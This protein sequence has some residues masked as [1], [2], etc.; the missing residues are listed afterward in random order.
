MI[1]DIFAKVYLHLGRAK[2]ATNETRN[3]KGKLDSEVFENFEKE[4][5]IL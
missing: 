5:F 3:W 4:N 1:D 2:S